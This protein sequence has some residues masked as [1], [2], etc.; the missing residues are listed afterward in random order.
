MSHYQEKLTIN[1]LFQFLEY[2][3]NYD[4]ISFDL[5]DTLIYRRYFDYDQVK[6]KVFDFIVNLADNHYSFEQVKFVYEH[7][8]NLLKDSGRISSDE[9]YLIDI[10]KTVLSALKVNESYADIVMQY[11]LDL[12]IKNLVLFDDVIPCLNRLK[13]SG[14]KIVILSDMYFDEL[15]IR[16]ILVSLNIEM[17]FDEV[18]VSSEYKERKYTSKL[19]RVIFGNNEN[20]LHIGDNEN[21]D[22]KQ[23]LKAKV[24]A[25]HL[26]RHQQQHQF[27]T[28]LPITYVNDEDK[29]IELMSEV[30]AGMLVNVFEYAVTH[31]IPK[32]FFLSRDATPLYVLAQ[33]FLANTKGGIYSNI[34]I[35]ELCIGRN[36]LGYLDVRHGKYFLE[37]I[38][39]QYAWLHHGKVSL[40]GLLDSFG[41]ASHKLP[42]SLVNTSWSSRK[43]AQNVANAIMNKDLELYSKI[44][45]YVLNQNRLALEYLHNM[46]AVGNGRVVFVDVGYSGTVLRYIAHHL[47]KESTSKLRMNTDIHMLML[48]TTDNYVSNSH[49]SQPY[50]VIREGIILTQSSLPSILKTNFSWLEVFFKNCYPQ[51]GPLLKYGQHNN[52]V[53]PIFKEIKQSA[54]PN[55]FLQKIIDASEKKLEGSLIKYL[56]HRYLVQ[57][58]NLVIET[59]SNPNKEVIDAMRNLKQEFSPLQTEVKGILLEAN[60]YTTLKKIDYMIKNDYWVAG[61]FKANGVGSLIA[62]FDEIRASKNKFPHW[63]ELKKEKLGVK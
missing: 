25:V 4:I 27:S 14:K 39:D 15:Q 45:E 53:V 1:N 12:E 49:F 43:S 23:A 30:F 47:T 9:P 20:V 13:E 59:F 19:F 52:E 62:K 40:L 36:S 7:I 41:I 38:L 17:F 51:R 22:Y 6:N 60:S 26:V 32:V 61:S 46:G 35:D 11:E 24:D 34:E 8:N 56:D 44:E 37:D 33:K 54:T 48:A 3:K 55:I 21:N 57:I 50:G 58:R 18:Y 63:F 42:E 16:Q 29:L 28:V 31:N 5:F 10:Y 2:T